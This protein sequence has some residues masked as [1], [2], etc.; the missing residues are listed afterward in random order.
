MNSGWARRSN[1]DLWNELDATVARHGT[2]VTF[3]WLRGHNG[4][5]HNERADR[6]ARAAA[7][8]AA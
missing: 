3:E 2:A 8:R 1:H 4:D 7:N 5:A 6:L